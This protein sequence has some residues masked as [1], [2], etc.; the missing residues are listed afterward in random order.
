MHICSEYAHM[1][2]ICKQHTCVYATYATYRRIY[3]ICSI[4]AYAAYMYICTYATNMH[5]CS[6]Y[7]C[8]IHA[9]IPHMQHICICSIY[10]Y[11][12]YMHICTYAAYMHI[13]STYACS[14]RGHSP[15]LNP[16]RASECPECSKSRR[17][18]LNRY[19]SLCPWQS[20]G[21]FLPSSIAPSQLQHAP[22]LLKT[23]RQ[24]IDLAPVAYP[25]A[26]V[27]GLH[28]PEPTSTRSTVP[29]D[30]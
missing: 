13:C 6:T 14:R 29:G 20:H 9:Y 16:S 15:I 5:I 21:I 27:A 26:I 11:A 1:Q 25:L 4:Y 23:V 22:A 7:A 12:A 18:F 28:R 24:R 3:H 2:H 8:S 19:T 17:N 30:Y 10:A